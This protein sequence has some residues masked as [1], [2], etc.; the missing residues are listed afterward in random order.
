M[1]FGSLPMHFEVHQWKRELLGP[2]RILHFHATDTA[3]EAAAKWLI[4]LTSDAP[5]WWEQ[6][7][8]VRPEK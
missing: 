2:G 3:L 5:P 6:I 4:D 7:S 8:P 1:K